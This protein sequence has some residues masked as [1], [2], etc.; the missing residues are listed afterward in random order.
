MGIK[1][2]DYIKGRKARGKLGKNPTGLSLAVVKGYKRPSNETIIAVFE[3]SA[4]VVS[5]TARKLNVSRTILYAWMRDD[6]SLKL[7]RDE[8]RAV[9]MDLAD[10]K[11]RELMLKGDRELLKYYTRCFGKDWGYVEITR[12]AGAEGGALQI[13]DVSHNPFA[14]ID[15]ALLSEPEV[16]ELQAICLVPEFS[17]TGKQS[18]RVKALVDKCRPLTID[19]TPVREIK[20]TKDK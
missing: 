17:K 9:T 1:D 14:G 12:V 13:E 10:G 5:E 19:I 3:A 15:L 4:G 2:S 6:P 11:I 18:A 7:A 20:E 8:F 16:I